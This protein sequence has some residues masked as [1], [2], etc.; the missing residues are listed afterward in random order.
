MLRRRTAQGAF[1]IALLA[2]VP[3]ITSCTT[4]NPSDDGSTTS[5]PTGSSAATS[6]PTA[7]PGLDAPPDRDP[8]MDTPSADGAA[9]AAEYFVGV[10]DYAYATGDTGEL[11]RLSSDACGFCRSAISDINQSHAA[12]ETEEG[13]G[14]VIE[15]ADGVEISPSEWYTA[16]LRVKQHASTRRSATGEVVVQ[17]PESKSDLYFALSWTD[18]WQVDA[19]DV[20]EPGSLTPS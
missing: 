17:D 7:P 4:G 12:G 5:S 6:S 9:A 20:M 2:A 14:T 3:S 13:G 10:Y 11:D 8:A 19:V 15:Y 18:G 16:T 1:A